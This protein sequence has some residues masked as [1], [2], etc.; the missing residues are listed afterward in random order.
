MELLEHVLATLIE[1][2]L[3]INKKTPTGLSSFRIAD[4]LLTSQSEVNSLTE[5]NQ[6][7]L[8]FDFNEKHL[9][10]NYN[11]DTPYSNQVVSKPKKA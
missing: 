11:I 5:N 2:N 9:L 1:N 3:V 10:A 4:D 8:N 7:E 6:E